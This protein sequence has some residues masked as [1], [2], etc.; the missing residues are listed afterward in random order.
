VKPSNDPPCR[1]R[2]DGTSARFLPSVCGYSTKYACVHNR[3]L[4]TFLALGAGRGSTY[5]RFFL[6]VPM[7][8]RVCRHIRQDLR[9]LASFFGKVEIFPAGAGCILPRLTC[10]CF[11]APPQRRLLPAS[12]ERSTVR[13]QRPSKVQAQDSARLQ[14]FSIRKSDWKAAPAKSKKALAALLPRVPKELQPQYGQ[15]SLVPFGRNQGRVSA[16]TEV[17]RCAPGTPVVPASA[18]QPSTIFFASSVSVA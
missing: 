5:V 18:T 15:G 2:G 14:G 13:D 16:A 9:R 12:C 4:L 11:G 7:P 1:H 6:Y 8:S 17:R 10:Q 3:R